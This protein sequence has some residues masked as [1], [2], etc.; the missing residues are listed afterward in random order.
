MR[1]KLYRGI[2]YL[3]GLLV[4][5]LGIILNTKTGLGV[6]PIV[7]VPY[8]AAQI[9]NWNFGNATLVFYAVLATAEYI[10]KGKNF[11]AYDLLQLPLSIVFTRFMN[12]FSA[13]LPD[14]H[15]IWARAVCLVFAIVCAGIGAAMTLDMRLV[16]NPGD[17]IVQAISDRLGRPLGLCKNCFDF[18]CISVTLLLGLVFTRQVIGI[19]LGTVA[20]V[21]GVGRVMALFQRLCAGRL[22]ALAGL[23]PE[24]ARADDGEA[25][26]VP[27]DPS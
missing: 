15:G 20:A 27:A 11:R 21:L 22:T 2:L 19:G 4:L 18:S 3:A 14:V 5:A 26:R 17:G 8:A 24:T 6:S 1:R 7:S 25:D 16:P 13:W 10:L 12:L 9:W 23:S